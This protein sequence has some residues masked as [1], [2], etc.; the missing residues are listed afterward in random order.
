MKLFCTTFRAVG[1]EGQKGDNHPLQ[2]LVGIEAKPS[3]SQRVI[4]SLHKTHMSHKFSNLPKV[5]NFLFRCRSRTA[6]EQ[7]MMRIFLALHSRFFERNPR[8]NHTYCTMYMDLTYLLTY[9]SN[10]YVSDWNQNSQIL[11]S[12]WKRLL[13][14]ENLKDNV[15]HFA[16]NFYNCIEYLSL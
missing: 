1:T 5:L 3:Y 2:I 7:I 14:Q 12:L 16:T 6:I 9:I 8:Y 11:Q 10:I 13:I 4:S 15:L